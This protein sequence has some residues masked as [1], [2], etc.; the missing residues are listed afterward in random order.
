MAPQKHPPSILI[1][2]SARP[3]RRRRSLLAKIEGENGHEADQLREHR[4]QEGEEENA[5]DVHLR[6]SNVELI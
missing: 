3:G 6:R 5:A 1:S 2:V 4:H